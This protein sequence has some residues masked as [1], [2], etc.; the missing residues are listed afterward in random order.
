MTMDMMGIYHYG[1]DNTIVVEN[2]IVSEKNKMGFT[3]D[4]TTPND[5]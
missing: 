4:I 5:Y 1:N 3:A 2:C